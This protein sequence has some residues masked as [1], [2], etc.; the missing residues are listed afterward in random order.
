MA[1]VC[2]VTVFPDIGSIG[3]GKINA[4][5]QKIKKRELPFVFEITYSFEL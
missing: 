5:D 3:L 2:R 1:A 4:V